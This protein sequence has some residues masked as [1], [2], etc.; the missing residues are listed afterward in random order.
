M[1]R[2]QRNSVR[3]GV[4]AVELAVVAPLLALMLVGVW[5]V[6]RMVEVQQLVTNAAR[7][8]GRQASTGSKNAASVKND[9]VNYLTVNGITGVTASM[10]T[11]TN[12]TNGSRSDPTQGSQ[13]DQYRVTVSMPFNNVRWILLNQITSATTISAT[14]DWYSMNDLPLTVATAIPLN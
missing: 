3:S 4:A 6:G 10:V 2:K 7:E 13:L 5:E 14:C 1:L 9:V 12:L 11:I 8:G